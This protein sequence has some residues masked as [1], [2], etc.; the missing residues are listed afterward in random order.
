MKDKMLKLW[1]DHRKILLL[2]VA[3]VFVWGLAAHGYTMLN[4]QLSHVS[5]DGL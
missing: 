2:C 4:F 5:L 1:T 3:A